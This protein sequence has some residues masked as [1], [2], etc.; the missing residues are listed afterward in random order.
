MIFCMFPVQPNLEV[1][2]AQGESTSLSETSTKDVV[3]KS[4]LSKP[5]GQGIELLLDGLSALLGRLGITVK[6]EALLGNVLELLAL[7][8]GQGGDGV[9]VD[10]L[11]QEK[12]LVALLQETLDEGRAGDLLLGATGDVVDGLLL[13]LHPLHVLGERGQ[14]TGGGGESQQLGQPRPVG[15]VL[16]DSELDVGGVLL[17]KLHVLVVGDLLDHEAPGEEVN[18]SSL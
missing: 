15:S 16:N 2:R 6:V 10:S 7:E 9:L 8:L 1:M 3:L 5:L 18:L 17:P 11:G 14:V 12:H 13:V 4:V